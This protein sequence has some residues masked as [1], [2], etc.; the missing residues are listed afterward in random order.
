MQIKVI[1]AI[2]SVFASLL[3]FISGFGLERYYFV[4]SLFDIE[5]AIAATL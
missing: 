3:T 1:I 2:A 5:V 4:F